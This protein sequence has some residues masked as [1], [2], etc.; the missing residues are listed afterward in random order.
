V[1]AH[2][3]WLI[4]DKDGKPAR[5]ARNL[6]TLCP[7]LPEVQAYYKQ[8]TE[9]FIRDWD[10]D[11]H[12]LDNIFATPRC[13]NPKHHHKSPD[14]S[15]NAMGD[16]YK[17]IFDTTR[18]LKPESVTQSCS[19]GTP[20]SLSWFRYMDQGVTGDPVGSAQVRRRIKMYK[21][22]LGA[23]AAVYGDHVELTRIIDP[24]T[25]KAQQL[26]QDFAS[27]MGTGGIPGTKFVWGD[28]GQKFPHIYL[29]PEKEA[30]WKQWIGLYND[31]MLSKGTFRDLYTLGY[32]LPEGYAI[33]KDGR[34]FYAFFGAEQPENQSSAK[35]ARSAWNGEVQLRGLQATRYRIF[36]YVHQKDYGVVEGPT[37]RLQVGF[38][39]SLLLEATPEANSMTQAKR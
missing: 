28:S 35:P 8:L 30:R 31:K 20:P 17:V 23:N 29:T 2:P 38:G 16:V 10:F 6:E 32:D 22:L 19:C 3:D 4:L 34:M 15:V 13:Y 25:S 18:A 27:T 39:D 5:M 26:G 33:E 11:G 14:D 21:A 9:H 1:K 37:A 24:N 12:K 36:D 7:A